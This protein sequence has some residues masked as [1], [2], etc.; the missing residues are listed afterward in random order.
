[1][2]PFVQS[3]GSSIIMI[4]VIKTP[5]SWVEKMLQFGRM[6]CSDL[7]LHL[8]YL[9][10]WP[11]FI[12]NTV[13]SSF[14]ACSRSDTALVSSPTTVLTSSFKVLLSSWLSLFLEIDSHNSDGR[15]HIITRDMYRTE[16]RSNWKINGKSTTMK[17]VMMCC[18]WQ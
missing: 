4:L 5:G 16:N 11:N 3:A 13:Y 14:V 15:N 7:L 2:F 1:M 12:M 9:W 8:V 10:W 18:T 17:E 6:Q